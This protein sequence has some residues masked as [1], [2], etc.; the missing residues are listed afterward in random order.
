MHH[1][2]GLLY[3]N[4]TPNLQSEKIQMAGKIR[5]MFELRYDTV[6]RHNLSDQ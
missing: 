4:K 6:E 1:I 2:V 3:C 5:L